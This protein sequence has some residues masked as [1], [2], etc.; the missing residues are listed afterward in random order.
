MECFAVAPAVALAE[1]ECIEQSGTSAS[2]W[3]AYDPRKIPPVMFLA[4]TLMQGS[5]CLSRET[6]RQPSSLPSLL[7]LA[8]SATER[9]SVA[10]SSCIRGIIGLVAPRRRERNVGVT[11]AC[12]L[13]GCWCKSCCSCWRCWKMQSLNHH[14]YHHTSGQL[15]L[16]DLQGILNR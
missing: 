14:S 3:Q 5:D 13:C 15:L 8:V 1:N 10:R 6:H 11:F 4:M 2:M 7:Q 12:R 9:G 16:C